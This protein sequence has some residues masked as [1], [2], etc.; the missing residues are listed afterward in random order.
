LPSLIKKIAIAIAAIFLLVGGMSLAL[1]WVVDADRRQAEI[2]TQLKETYGWTFESVSKGY[3]TTFPHPK[4]YFK[5]VTLKNADGVNIVQAPS[6]VVHLGWTGIASGSINSIELVQPEIYTSYRQLQQMFGHF[7]GAAAISATQLPTSL[8]LTQATLN[9]KK[10]E[11]KNP[12]AF[13][14][15]N[16]DITLPVPNQP[17]KISATALLNNQQV[18]IEALLNARVGQKSTALITL[19]NNTIALDGSLISNEPALWQ[20]KLRANL[21]NIAEIGTTTAAS[22]ASN[23]SAIP[24]VFEADAAIDSESFSFSKTHAQIDDSEGTIAAY[25][26]WQKNLVIAFDVAAKRIDIQNLVDTLAPSLLLR[27]VKQDAGVT[28]L[29][30]NPTDQDVGISLLLSA[31]EATFGANK[32]FQQL[33]TS[34]EFDQGNLLIQHLS[35]R[36]AGDTTLNIEGAMTHQPEGRRFSGIADLKGEH[37]NLWLADFE[38]YAKNL[39]E[40]DFSKFSLQGNLFISAKQLRLSEATLLINQFELLGGFATYFEKMPRVEAEVKFKNANLDYFRDIWRTKRNASDDTTYNL[41]LGDSAQFEWLRK[42]PAILDFNIA[43][44]GF[45]FLDNDGQLA[46]MRL[47]MTP[48]EANLYG[49]DIRFPDNTMNGNIKFNAIGERPKLD[50]VL[51][52]NQL[53]TDYFNTDKTS[54]NVPWFDAKNTTARWSDKLF[55]VRWMS[56]IDG[57]MDLSVGELLHNGDAYQNFKWRADLDKATMNIQK[58]AFDYLRGKFDLNGTLLGGKVPSLSA[59]FALYNGDVKE[60]LSTYFNTD[61]IGGRVSLTGVVSASGINMKTWA[62][63]GDMKLTTVARGVRV[64]GLNLQSVLD[65]TSAA[66]STQDVAEGV[67]NLLYDGTTELTVDGN[68]NFQQGT[69]KTPGIRLSTNRITGNLTGEMQLLPWTLNLSTEWQFPELSDTTTIPTMTTS[70][71]GGIN[72][73]TTRVDTASLEAFVAKRII[74]Q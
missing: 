8:L 59:S 52:A 46:N 64:Q 22:N 72:E 54:D 18:S 56:A 37:L 62:E 44:D 66:R 49:V 3:V 47:Y 58:L 7:T 57:S 32:Q 5:D 50:I 30:I 2:T 69:I 31:D 17:A 14:Q 63:Q 68:I 73:Y 25:I 26:G 55:D 42:L 70:Q 65:T 38:P 33:H 4:L 67:R 74:G 35:V 40:D 24:M 29:I 6:I 61:H 34:A 21:S 27:A 16:A 41:L 45:R 43:I 1:P 19:N 60:L 51:S 23:S 9:I 11:D 12:T 48:G 28:P 36:M 20:G 13:R 39:P 71:Q 10:S 15:L 53:N